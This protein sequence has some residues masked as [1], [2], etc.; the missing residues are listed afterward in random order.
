VHGEAEEALC[1]LINELA[2]WRRERLLALKMG[3]GERAWLKESH[4]IEVAQSS[5]YKYLGKLQ[6]RV[7]VPRP[8]LIKK[9]A[10]AVEAFKS[11]LADKLEAL[12]I[13]EGRPI[14]L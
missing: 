1:L 3:L 8:V 14:R 5:V 7:R 2:G 4:G 12:E 11:S 6:T 9:D 13:S 10:A